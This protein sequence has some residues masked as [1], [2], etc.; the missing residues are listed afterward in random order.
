MPKY[1]LTYYGGDGMPESPDEV[2]AVMAK[3]EA[4]FG[5]LGE[6]VVDGGNPFSVAKT[7]S[8]GGG[9]ADSAGDPPITGYSV[10]SADD[11]DDATEKGK[12]CPV[13][14]NNGTVV[15]SEAIDM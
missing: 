6:A 10:I 2:Q 4:W 3:W 12:G 15:V 1:V 13:L 11:I 7:I 9:V 14:E 8:P 5:Q